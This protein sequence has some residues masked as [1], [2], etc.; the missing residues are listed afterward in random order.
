MG[1]CRLRPHGGR[2]CGMGIDIG[3][4]VG[5]WGDSQERAHGTAWFD[6]MVIG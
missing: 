5:D 4:A 1:L 6:E 3:V 2:L